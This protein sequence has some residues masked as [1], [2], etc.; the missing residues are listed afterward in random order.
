MTKRQVICT[1][2]EAPS[3][4]ELVAQIA[5][6]TPMDVGF[7]PAFVRARRFTHF[8][9][10][11]SGIEYMS[12]LDED[13]NILWADTVTLCLAGWVDCSCDHAEETEIKNVH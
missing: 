4:D 13:G 2:I 1:V 6:F 10:E 5:E 3:V 7:I 9:I 11:D 8:Q 12:L